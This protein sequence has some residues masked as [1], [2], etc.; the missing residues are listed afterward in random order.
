MSDAKLLFVGIKDNTM[1]LAIAAGQN[2]SLIEQLSFSLPAVATYARERR[3][4]QVMP[5]GANTFAPNGN[6]VLTFNVTSQDGWLD[7]SSLRLHFRIR[8]TVAAGADA[9]ANNLLNLRAASGCHC[10]FSQ[11][12]ILIGG[13]EV[14]RIEPYNMLHEL[15]RVALNTP[16]SQVEQGV[17][18]GRHTFDNDAYPPVIPIMIAQGAYLSVTLTPLAGLLQCGKYLPLRLMNSMILEFTLARTDDALAPAVQP[19][20]VPAP[21]IANLSRNFELQQCELQFSTVRL[22]SALEAGFSSMML[23][24]RAL[25][26][27]LR[28]IMSQ[29]AIIPAAAVEFQATVVRALSRIAAVFVTFQGRDAQTNSILRF[30]NPSA[31]V[32]HERLL[33][34]SVQIGSKT[35]PEMSTCKSQ[36]STMSLLKQALGIYDQNIACTCI[37]PLNYNGTRYVIGVPTST[38]PGQVFSG[39]ST[40]SGD[41]LSVL[42]KSMGIAANEQA[43]KLH[44]S[45]VAEVILELK[46]SGTVLL[47]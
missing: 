7:P 42:I 34:W 29:Q 21:Q 27:N 3:L 24:G 6:Q 15:F 31:V 13:T 44:I 37:N 33:E 16:Q 46:E 22:D 25:Q 40:R 20:A 26:L 2:D 45:M 12:R 5:Q 28:T 23:S 47:E 9:A 39:I 17:E 35:W 11:L 43:Q 19:L 38:I 18:D 32:N 30:H 4:V 8:N 41:L 1:D 10:F 14:E 36:A